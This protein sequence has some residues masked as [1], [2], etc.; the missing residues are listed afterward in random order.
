MINSYLHR[1]GGPIFFG[2]SLI[3]LFL[4]L[5]ALRWLER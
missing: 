5:R 1:G 4:L 3:P 2:L